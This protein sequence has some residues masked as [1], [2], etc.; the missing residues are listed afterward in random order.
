MYEYVY[1]TGFW[2]IFQIE[3]VKHFW[4]NFKRYLLNATKIILYVLKH[5]SYMYICSR[6]QKCGGLAQF[7][8]KVVSDVLL[9]F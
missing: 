6:Q 3:K 5:V 8:Y 7:P 2:K 9:R 4:V 1:K